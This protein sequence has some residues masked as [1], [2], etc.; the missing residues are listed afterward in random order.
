[1]TNKTVPITLAQTPQVLNNWAPVSKVLKPVVLSPTLT[2]KVTSTAEEISKETLSNQTLW[3]ATPTATTKV[4]LTPLPTPCFLHVLAALVR[5][6]Q[7]LKSSRQNYYPAKDNSKTNNHQTNSLRKKSSKLN[8][9]K[10]CCKL[11]LINNKRK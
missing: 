2:L 11:H 1:M 6:L 4:Q 3:Q 10:T 7:S 8:M 5:T 9:K